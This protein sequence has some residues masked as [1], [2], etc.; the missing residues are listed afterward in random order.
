MIERGENGELRRMHC[1][2][3]GR[4][5]YPT[6]PLSSVGLRGDQEIDICGSCQGTLVK[7]GRKWVPR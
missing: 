4:Q 7:V 5:T 2:E 3:C 6:L 1:H